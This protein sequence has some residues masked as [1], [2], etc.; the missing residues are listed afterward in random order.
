M[1][2]R[3]K[4]EARPF[5]RVLAAL[6][7]AFFIFAGAGSLTVAKGRWEGIGFLASGVSLLVLALTGRYVGL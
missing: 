4:A 2:T 5:F 1:K 7:G 6:L 3:R